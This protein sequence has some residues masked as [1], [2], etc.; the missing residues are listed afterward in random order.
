[1]GDL[2]KAPKNGPNFSIGQNRVNMLIEKLYFYDPPKQA[3]N[4]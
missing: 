3:E 2:K 1:M 4:I